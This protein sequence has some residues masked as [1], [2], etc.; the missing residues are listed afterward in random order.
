MLKIGRCLVNQ[1]IQFGVVLYIANIHQGQDHYAVLGLS[2]YRYRATP[3]QIK[4]AHRRKVLRH[5]PDKKAASGDADEND[6]FFKCIQKATEIL[7]DP[8]RRRQFDSVDQAADVPP[9]KNKKGNFFKLW[10]PVFESEARFSKILP[11]PKLG[12]ENSTKEEVETFWL[13][14]VGLPRTCLTK[15]TVNAYSRHSQRKRLNM[16]PYG[17]CR[18]TVNSTRILQ[19]IYGAIQEYAGFGR[20]AWLG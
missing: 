18:V 11:V 20:A 2:K 6:S 7:L 5:H 4:L 10:N 17:T 9:P 16:L 14:V 1:L 13:E 3:E 19:S 8:V 12:N 15:S